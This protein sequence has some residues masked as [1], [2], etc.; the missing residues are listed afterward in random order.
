MPTQ[1]KYNSVKESISLTDQ[2]VI[3]PVFW[4]HGSQ[5]NWCYDRIFLIFLLNKGCNDKSIPKIKF[6]AVEYVCQSPCR[7]KP[8][9]MKTSILFKAAFMK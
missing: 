3:F 4:W 2:L 5:K 9:E 8:I 7:M 6:N 1:L